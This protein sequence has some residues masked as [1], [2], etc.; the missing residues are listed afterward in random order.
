MFARWCLKSPKGYHSSYWP[1]ARLP[2]LCV[3]LAGSHRS[4]EIPSRRYFTFCFCLIVL[5]FAVCPLARLNSRHCVDASNATIIALPSNRSLLCRRRSFF[6]PSER[7]SPLEHVYCLLCGA[8]LLFFFA[9][10]ACDGSGKT[11]RNG[12]NRIE[13]SVVSRQRLH[14]VG[15]GKGT[16]FEMIYIVTASSFCS[17]GLGPR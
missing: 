16:D 7:P 2:P 13:S 11:N 3:V 15:K 9:V 4:N 14:L 5:S 10:D 12:E 1:I 8:A 17:S 6:L